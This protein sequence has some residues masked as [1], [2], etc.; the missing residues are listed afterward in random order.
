MR[1]EVEVAADAVRVPLARRRVAEIARAVLRTERARPTRLSITFVSTRRIARINARHLGHQGPTDVISFA[2][3]P[4]ATSAGRVGDI[5]IAP[6]I[7]RRNARGH[8]TPV[9]EEIV[10]L[11]VHG[12]LH[13]LGY[14]HPE[15]PGRTTSRMW[16]R[17]EALVAMMARFHEAGHRPRRLTRAAA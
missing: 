13:V 6:A 2:L 4:A 8:G 10:R 17:Q 5:Y 3:A 12:V 14:D 16:R 11:V 1:Y 15:G 9:R 7:A